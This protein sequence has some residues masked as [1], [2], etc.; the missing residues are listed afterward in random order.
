MKCAIMQPTYL[1]WSGYLNLVS[2]VDCFIFLDDVQFQRRSWQSR[3]RIMINGVELMLSVPTIKSHR[4]TLL[5][6]IE[7]CY[8]NDW[9]SKHWKSLV[10]GYEK[11]E[12]GK[13]L[14]SIMEPIYRATKIAYLAELNCLIIKTLC[15]A[16]NIETKFLYASELNCIGSRSLHLI[17]LL[18][19]CKCSEYVSPIGSKEY[20]AED[21]FEE[22]SSIKLTYQ[23]FSPKP[24]PQKKSSGFISHLSVVDLIANVGVSKSKEYIAA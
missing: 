19:K 1:P 5:K 3:N 6:D 21:R 24:Y 16:L 8:E 2:R 20:L 11:A 17:E 22:H 4:S 13:E 14:L 12:H 9:V 7:I 15:G 23:D 18:K 10:L